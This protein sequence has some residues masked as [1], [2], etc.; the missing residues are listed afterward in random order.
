MPRLLRPLASGSPKPSSL[1][2]RGGGSW[3]SVLAYSYP[4]EEAEPAPEPPSRAAKLAAAD[5]ACLAESN[6]PL[7]EETASC[8]QEELHAIEVTVVDGREEPLANVPVELRKSDTEALT[9]KTDATGWLRLDGLPAGSYSLTLPG[10][11]R[12]A[13]KVLGSEKLPP[14]RAASTGHASWKPPA[15][16]PEALTHTVEQGEGL[17]ELA[18]RYG[19]HPDTL[20][21]ANAELHEP[22]PHRNVL[23]PGDT[24]KVPKPTLGTHSVAVGEHHR[25][26]RCGIVETLQL[27]FLDAEGKPRAGL[28]YLLTLHLPGGDEVRE[29]KTNGSGH[30]DETVPPDL[31]RATLLLDQDG[32]VETYALSINHLDPVEDV[33][34]VQARLLGL[35]HALDPAELGTLGPYTVRSLRDFQAHAKL[36]QSGQLDDATLAKLEALHLS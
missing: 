14:E 22:R 26:Q 6:A 20:W 11:D 27:R 18:K 24:V 15:A 36:E 23:A 12:D 4:Q 17:S 10:L 5:E 9:A 28:P 8:A 3:P 19:F 13:W 21:E 32:L 2:V 35:G 31:D 33:T 29:G 25:L 34:G 7:V 1:S 16:L 30:V